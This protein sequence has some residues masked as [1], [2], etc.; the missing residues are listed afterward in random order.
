[1]R[2]CAIRY[3]EMI[4]DMAEEDLRLACEQQDVPWQ[5]SMEARLPRTLP[6]GW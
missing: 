4:E 2:A 1:M 3:K 6:P 5:C